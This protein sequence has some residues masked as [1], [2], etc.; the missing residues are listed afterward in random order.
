MLLT[1]RIETASD[2]AG[3]TE[4]NRLAFGGEAEPA[5]V[6][7]LRDGG[8]V[9]LSLIAA[10]E[11][12]VVGHILFSRLA[13]VTMR[14]VVEAL[15]LAP[16]AVRS[17][18]QRKGIGSRL[19][20]ESLR[21]CREQ[22]HRV[23]LVLGHPSFYPRFGFSAVLAQRVTEPFSGP[24]WMAMELAPGALDG[25]TGRAEYPLIAPWIAKATHWPCRGI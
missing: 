1:F 21:I 25:V 24:A 9:R 19:V 23:V 3:I 12:H 8:H 5:L 13:I 20:Q 7:A 14:G 18:H 10:A 22:G 2:Y 6:T 16:M 15:A 4:V 11:G 17:T